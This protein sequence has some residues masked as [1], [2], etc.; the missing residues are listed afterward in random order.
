MTRSHFVAVFTALGVA[1]LTGC[2]AK[3]AVAPPVLTATVPV[4]EAAPPPPPMVV[5]PKLATIC[6]AEIKLDG[7]MKFPGEVEFDSGKATIKM[8]PTSTHILTCLS[9]FFKA[10]PSVT[11][12]RLEGHTDSQGDEKSNVILSQARADAV[13]G[14]LVNNGVPAGMFY[15]KGF[16]PSRPLVPNDSPEHMQMNRRVEFH[17][18]EVDHVHVSPERVAAWMKPTTVAVAAP[19]APAVV[20]VGVAVPT[21]AVT[22]PS[23]TVAAPAVAVPTSVSIGIGGGGSAPGKKK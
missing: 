5:P 6:D 3:V 1:G 4:V 19:A 17:I 13:I 10:N 8:S 20:G 22:A 12:F 11:K 18:D 9:D 23:V 21:V 2:S 15:G 7:H 14:W 16:G